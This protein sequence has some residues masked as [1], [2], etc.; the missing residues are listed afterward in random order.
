M[1][2]EYTCETWKKSVI[3]PYNDIAND[4]GTKELLTI[5]SRLILL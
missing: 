5:A 1:M 3:T 4:V 2:R